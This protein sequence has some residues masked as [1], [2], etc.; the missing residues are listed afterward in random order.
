MFVAIMLGLWFM[1]IL[2][3]CF[4]AYRERRKEERMI[5]EFVD[6]RPKLKLVRDCHWCH[7]RPCVCKSGTTWD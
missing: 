7:S 2:A 5:A 4:V 1:G 3:L 6:P